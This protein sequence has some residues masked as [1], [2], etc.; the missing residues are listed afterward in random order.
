[1]LRKVTVI[2]IGMLVSALGCASTQSGQI[3]RSPMTIMLETSESVESWQQTARGVSSSI[4]EYEI[5]VEPSGRDTRAFNHIEISEQGT[6][7]CFEPQVNYDYAGNLTGFTPLY[8]ASIDESAPQQSL[9]EAVDQYQSRFIPFQSE[10][11]DSQYRAWI[12][13]HSSPDEPLCY[14]VYPGLFAVGSPQPV[15]VEENYMLACANAI[16][17]DSSWPHADTALLAARLRTEAA[18]LSNQNGF[19]ASAFRS[20]AVDNTLEGN[21]YGIALEGYTELMS[22]KHLQSEM[23][24]IEA[25][26]RSDDSKL[27]YLSKLNALR[28][29]YIASRAEDMSMERLQTIIRALSPREKWPNVH[30]DMRSMLQMRTCQMLAS[31]PEMTPS[32]VEDCLPWLR[33]MVRTSDDFE[34]ALRIIEQGIYG[35]K[36]D[37]S[38]ISSDVL[39]WLRFAPLFGELLDLRHV[40]GQR[41]AHHERFTPEERDILLGF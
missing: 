7:V 35:A 17:G 20:I 25:L 22:R 9:I 40:F 27:F 3:T 16:E 30:V 31:M 36:P 28:L 4:P 41:N 2:S 34:M 19:I 26:R 21:V 23:T 24:T 1:M 39:S 37:E 32:L 11:T 6:R 15:P 14:S 8:C 33:T 29:F 13:S 5:S 18:M 12:L 38:P 10:L